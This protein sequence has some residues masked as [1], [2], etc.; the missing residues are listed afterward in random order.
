LTSRKS[1]GDQPERAPPCLAA[2]SPPTAAQNELHPSTSFQTA[3]S[4]LLL[5]ASKFLLAPRPT[6]TSPRLLGSR[7]ER[8]G[9]PFPFSWSWTCF[10]P[11]RSLGGVSCSWLRY[12]VALGRRMDVWSARGGG[13]L[14]RH[15]PFLGRAVVVGLG[16]PSGGRNDGANGVLLP[17]VDGSDSGACI[18]RHT[19]NQSSPYPCSRILCGL[20]LTPVPVGDSVSAKLSVVRFIHKLAAELFLLLLLNR[21]QFRKTSTQNWS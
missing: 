1:W 10:S 11:P 5:P 2:P 16:F 7:L 13:R 6:T 15:S 12:L 8:A 9:L 21:F 18:T 20:T 4:S 14:G 3:K 17:S 19:N